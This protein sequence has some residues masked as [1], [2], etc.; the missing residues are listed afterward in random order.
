MVV[1]LLIAFLFFVYFAPSSSADEYSKN[2]D[3]L[4]SEVRSN[5]LTKNGYWLEMRNAFEEWEKMILVFGYADPGDEAAC[6]RIR[7]LASKEYPDRL[8]RCNSVN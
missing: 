6:R 3:D 1:R 8:Y 2:M 5:P 4:S 7:N